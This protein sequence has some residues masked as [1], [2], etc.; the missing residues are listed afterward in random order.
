MRARQ[1]VV[2]VPPTARTSE[3]LAPVAGC[4]VAIAFDSLVGRISPSVG[5]EPAA[6]ALALGVSFALDDPAASSL[7]ASPVPLAV[8]HAVRAA[9]VVPL[10]AAV[11]V[12]LAT[13]SDAPDARTL[14]LEL[15]SLVALA[16]AIAA[17]ATRVGEA[18]GPLAAPAV[19]GL[20]AATAGLRDAI[21][22]VVLWTIVLAV[23]AA[24]AV[25]A[26]R[27]PAKG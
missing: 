16:L 3:W 11:W 24:L 7:E 4:A 21:R 25:A 9:C 2:L 23:A 12:V 8:R 27:D 10:P 6:V 13:R 15:A 1:L 5:L 19:L 18:G 22:P 17:L 14:S 20:V 26:C